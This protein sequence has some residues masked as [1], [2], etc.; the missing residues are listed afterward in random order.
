[1]DRDFSE[2]AIRSKATE[3]GRTKQLKTNKLFQLNFERQ[4]L[5]RINN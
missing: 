2:T 4:F 1:M 5:A 3:L